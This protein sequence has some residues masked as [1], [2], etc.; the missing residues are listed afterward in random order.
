ML[1][2]IRA[3][4]PILKWSSRN[5]WL[6]KATC[7]GSLILGKTVRMFSATAYNRDNT[8]PVSDGES[9]NHVDMKN[10]T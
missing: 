10:Y 3:A 4:T 2:P 1:G 5:D 9:N 7:N 8:L 6:I